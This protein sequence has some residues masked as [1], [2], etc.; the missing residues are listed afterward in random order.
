MSP[1]KT[2]VYK[3]YLPYLKDFVYVVGIAVSLLGW[4]KTKSKNEAILETTIKYN[5]EAVEKLE[6][7][8]TKQVDLNGK[9]AEINGALIEFKNSHTH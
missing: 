4:I 6:D 7:F 2:P 3:K 1:V 8:V 9:Q 5:T